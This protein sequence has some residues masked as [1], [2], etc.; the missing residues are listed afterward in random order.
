MSDSCFRAREISPGVHWVGA[1]DWDVRDFH[2]YET[3]LGSTYNAF[4]VTGEQNV[5][6]D[7]VKAPFRTELL[8]RVASVT[9]RVDVLIS[10]HSEPDHTGALPEVLSALRPKRFLASKI[11][12]DTLMAHFHDLPVRPE[13]VE[14]GATLEIGGNSFTFLETRM[15]HWPDSM[16]T[17]MPKRNI[18][19]SQDAFGMHMA[20]ADLMAHHYD[21]GVLRRESAMYYANI[22]NPFSKLVAALLGKVAGLG[23]KPDIIAPDHGPIW[24]S[25]TATGPEWVTGL[26]KEWAE[27]R[28]RDS[29]VILYDTM[30]NSTGLMAR[31]IAEGASSLN[32]P[33]RVLKAGNVHRSV[34]A[35]A[36]LSAGAVALGSPTLNN[37]I[38][39]ALSDHIEYLRGL[40]FHDRAC[41]AFG[42]HGWSGEAVPILEKVLSEWKGLPAG[43]SV[44]VKFAPTSEDMAKCRALGVELARAIRA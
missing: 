24:F 13:A 44:A 41:A 37:G 29:A 36:M 8:E 7:T 23:I 21:P 26:W 16:F 12:A 39:P 17:F 5:L 20:G 42:S 43:G 33:V 14:N 27:G 32:V 28:N 40:R 25:G 10:N 18:L 9:D 1:I 19:F 15:L 3:S 34:A 38:F 4:L 11:G 6:I 35:L 2:G 22:L 30:W 31:A